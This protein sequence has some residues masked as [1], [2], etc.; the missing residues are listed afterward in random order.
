MKSHTKK[1]HHS[2]E[3]MSIQKGGFKK[4]IISMFVLNESPHSLIL[5]SLQFCL[6]IEKTIYATF[7]E[8]ESECKIFR[9]HFGREF[10]KSSSYLIILS[11]NLFH[12]IP[13]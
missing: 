7:F 10:V 11:A 5:T 9:I 6:Q 2:P 3:N 12:M 4:S 8:K 13:T 1:S